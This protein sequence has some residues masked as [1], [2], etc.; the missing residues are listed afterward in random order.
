[1]TH[2]VSKHAKERLGQRYGS[3]AG[4]HAGAKL[5]ALWHGGRDADWTDHLAF[6]A[7]KKHGFQYRVSR[8]CRGEFMIVYDPAA[9]TFVTVIKRRA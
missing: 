2:R 8:T 7:A 5:R 9:E 4:N 1:M 3:G 6:A